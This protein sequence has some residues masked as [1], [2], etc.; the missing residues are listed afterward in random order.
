MFQM[1][2]TTDARLARDDAELALDAEHV[3][4]DHAEAKAEQRRVALGR[5]VLDVA[6]R[7]ARSSSLKTWRP[8]VPPIS[9]FAWATE[10]EAAVPSAATITG[11]SRRFMKAPV[12]GLRACSYPARA[13]DFHILG[14][15]IEGSQPRRL[16]LEVGAIHP[17]TSRESGPDGPSQRRAWRV[18]RK[19][20]LTGTSRVFGQVEGRAGRA[21]A[22]LAEQ[23]E[24]RDRGGSRGRAARS[25]DERRRY[26]VRYEHA[27]ADLPR[28]AGVLLDGVVAIDRARSDRRRARPRHSAR[29]RRRGRPCSARARQGRVTDAR[30]SERC[31]RGSA[32][33]RARRRSARPRARR[34]RS[35]ANATPS[36]ELRELFGVVFAS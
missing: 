23:L 29:R 13:P 31:R 9:T 4:E 5:R 18:Y 21:A 27:A 7:R 2:N 1:S 8:A 25:T 24:Q 6:A 32:D 15:L 26:A 35:A 14:Q 11:R 28:V 12:R 3:V 22:G 33:R 10:P 19:G 34:R 16:A 17:Q 36:R 30:R 20:R